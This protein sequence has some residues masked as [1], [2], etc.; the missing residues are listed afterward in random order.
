MEFIHAVIYLKNYFCSRF[1][2]FFVISNSRVFSYVKAQFRGFL[3]VDSHFSDREFRSKD[4]PCMWCNLNLPLGVKRPRVMWKL[5][6]SCIC[7]GVVLV[8]WHGLELKYSSQNS[9]GIAPKRIV[10]SNPADIRPE[11]YQII[12]STGLTAIRIEKRILIAKLWLLHKIIQKIMLY[13]LNI[14]KYNSKSNQQ[15]VVYVVSMSDIDMQWLVFPFMLPL[16][17]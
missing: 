6:E 11:D 7:S 15:P 9:A 5:G 13:I 17:R 14:T 10:Y 12:D 16:W 3:L 2:L 4:F 8:I 1:F